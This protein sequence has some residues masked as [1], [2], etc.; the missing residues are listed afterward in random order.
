MEVLTNLEAPEGPQRL[1][2]EARQ[3]VLENLPE[4]LSEEQHRQ[5]VDM[6]DRFGDVFSENK[7]DMGRT[8]LVEHT[9]DTGGHLSLIH[10]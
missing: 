3:A 8:H 10:I 7:F 2:E 5:V 1:G 9:I 4:Y 6:L